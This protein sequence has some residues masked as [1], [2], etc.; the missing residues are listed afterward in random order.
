MAVLAA[1]NPIVPGADIP[2]TYGQFITQDEFNARYAPTADAEQ[3]V[4]DYLEANGFT[5]TDRFSNHL[6]VGALGSVAAL[7]QAFGVQSHHVTLRGKPHYAAINEPVWPAD[8]AGD[9]VGIVGLDNLSAMHAHLRSAQP[10]IAPSAALGTYCCGL[11]G[12]NLRQSE[13]GGPHAICH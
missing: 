6:L 4:A 8:I 12:F 1:G 5:V 10:A 7:E 9:V 13:K 2:P 11:I 3:R